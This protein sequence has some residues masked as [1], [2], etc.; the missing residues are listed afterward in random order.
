MYLFSYRKSPPIFL[1]LRTQV[2]C[3]PMQIWYFCLLAYANHLTHACF[4]ILSSC[5]RKIVILGFLLTPYA[6][7]HSGALLTTPRKKVVENA[8]ETIFIQMRQ[9][10]K[11]LHNLIP[12]HV[13]LA[14]SE[15]NTECSASVQTT[16][17]ARRTSSC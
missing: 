14:C 5:V 12:S 7:W 1:S 10:I 4:G 3:L 11:G 2:I 13:F 16:G 17:E 15:N 8:V 9:K 6:K